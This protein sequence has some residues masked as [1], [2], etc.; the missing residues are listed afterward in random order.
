MVFEMVYSVAPGAA[1]TAIDKNDV[2]GAR[3]NVYANTLQAVTDVSQYQELRCRGG[4]G[5]RF[6]ETEGRTNSSGEATTYMTVYF[7]PAAQSASSGL[8]LQPGQCAFP[9]RTVR[10]DEPY[11]IILEV[12]NFGQRQ[13]QRHGTPVDTSPTA[14]EKYPDAQN[15]PLYLADASHNWSFFVHQNAPL[16][17]GRFEAS[18]AGH[19]WKPAIRSDETVRPIES[20]GIS[21]DPYVLAPKKRH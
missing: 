3:D 15:V 12:V 8:N 18:S 19:Y 5:L 13:Q 16:P 21:K 2:R 9:E 11:E 17:S 10:A 20:K 14:A 1:V 4:A 7:R 6:V